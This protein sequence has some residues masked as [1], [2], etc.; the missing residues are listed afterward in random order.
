[1]VRTK[2][3]KWVKAPLSKM[4]GPSFPRDLYSGAAYERPL[5]S[6]SKDALERYCHER[7]VRPMRLPWSSQ[8]HPG[9][10]EPV[11]RK[12]SKSNLRAY[13]EMGLSY[14]KGAAHSRPVR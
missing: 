3:P 4:H 9:L 10:Y 13:V 8:T 11:I 7:R 1:D 5:Y 6:Y 14:P 2:E 12:E